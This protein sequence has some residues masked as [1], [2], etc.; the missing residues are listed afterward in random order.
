MKKI[1]SAISFLHE[2]ERV[3]IK[4]TALGKFRVPVSEVRNGQL[5]TRMRSL[6][7]MEVI[8]HEIIK[9]CDPTFYLGAGNRMR[10]YPGGD[11]SY[12]PAHIEGV[13][14]KHD[15]ANKLKQ[16][17]VAPKKSILDKPFSTSHSSNRYNQAGLD[18]Y[19]WYPSDDGY[20]D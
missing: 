20:A 9:N 3:V 8:R 16:P 6:T 14:L 19:G 1:I 13:A 15:N 7:A 4:S 18:M 2:G 12:L 17:K 5:K 10:V 11:S